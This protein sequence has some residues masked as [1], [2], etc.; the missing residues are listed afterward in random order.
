MLKDGVPA[1]LRE[2]VEGHGRGERVPE[3][4]LPRLRG[5]EAHRGLEGE[6]LNRA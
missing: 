2:V 3:V 6:F 4:R 1:E 5:G